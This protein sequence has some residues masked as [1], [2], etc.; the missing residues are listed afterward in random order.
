MLGI[1]QWSPIIAAL[2]SPRVILRRFGGSDRLG[3]DLFMV[4][5]VSVILLPEVWRR[6]ERW[7]AIHHKTSLTAELGLG[8][9]V[10]FVV[11]FF[12]G[13]VDWVVCAC[14]TICEA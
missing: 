13:G 11:C 1:E 4:R 12:L 8:W 7:Q 3:T 14:A 5:F 6:A 9:V 10:G 2:L